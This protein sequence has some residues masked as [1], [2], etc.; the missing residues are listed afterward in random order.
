MAIKFRK[1]YQ[2]KLA[3]RTMSVFVVSV[4]IIYLIAGYL[5]YY[6]NLNELDK[7]FGKKLIRVADAASEEITPYSVK[8]LSQASL[9]D[10]DN[11]RLVKR[12]APIMKSGDIENITIL[13]IKQVTVFDLMRPEMAGVRN[14]NTYAYR[15]E[16]EKAFKGTASYSPLYRGQDRHLYKSAFHPLTSEK[17][18]VEFVIAVDANP[19]FL[20]L[21]DDILKWI[22]ISGAA[23][24]CVTVF[25]SLL[26]ANTVVK[27]VRKLE[28]V[29]TQIKD[30]NFNVSIDSKG[31]DEIDQLA[32]TFNHMI[33][34]ISKKIE[35][36]ARLAAIGEMSA[37]IAHEIRNPL[38]SIQIYMDILRKKLES[39]KSDSEICDRV[40]KEI[41]ILNNF[42][43]EF[44]VFSRPP[45]LDL[46]KHPVHSL[47]DEVTSQL[48]ISS[49]RDRIEIIKEYTEEETIINIDRDQ[50][51]RALFNVFINSIQAMKGQG[52]ITIQTGRFNGALEPFNEADG[53]GHE[54]DTNFFCIKIRDNGPGID[55]KN[56][57]K[58]FDPFF[59]TKNGGTGLGLSIT[60][61]II[62]EHNGEIK[63]FSAASGTEIAIYLPV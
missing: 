3:T 24:L 51:K 26:F 55:E 47:I 2:Q 5:F 28:Q 32:E 63:I 27:K 11:N 10:A 37:G 8:L 17:G 30:G 39:N 61:K 29:A 50:I 21:I 46:R 34:S 12:L 49:E 20:Q 58:V 35:H 19:Q 42:I 56:I 48:P 6:I 15:E 54:E 16:I 7:D 53:N 36:N 52:T 18:E 41:E 23:S 14:P 60:Q 62:K 44:L 38:G 1:G 40:S 57:D 25:L 13:N 22:A 43:T 45:S 4:I 31:D 9:S 59:S 33:R